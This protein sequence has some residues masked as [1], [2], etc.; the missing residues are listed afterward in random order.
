MAHGLQIHVDGFVAY[1]EKWLHARIR[2]LGRN[3]PLCKEGRYF[4]SVVVKL[5]PTSVIE[6]GASGL[7]RSFRSGCRTDD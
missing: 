4:V 7:P 1:G 3:T 5:K 2:C 6:Q